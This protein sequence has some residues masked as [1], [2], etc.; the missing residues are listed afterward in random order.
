M[1]CSGSGVLNGCRVGIAADPNDD[2]GKADD[3]NSGDDIGAI[4]RLRL[5]GCVDL[6]GTP[7]ALGV[8]PSLT[9][10][11]GPAGVKPG[12]ALVAGLATILPMVGLR[13]S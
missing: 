4:E 2:D 12:V 8:L 1:V 11:G 6:S 13:L 9:G 10:W 3:G 5:N 7:A